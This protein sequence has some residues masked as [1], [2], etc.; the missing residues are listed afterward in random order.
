M[1]YAT[2][3]TLNKV[4]WKIE[5][6]YRHIK[7]AHGNQLL[8]FYQKNGKHTEEKQSRTIWRKDKTWRFDQKGYWYYIYAN[9]KGKYV[10]YYWH[11]VDDRKNEEGYVHMGQRATFTVSQKFK[12][13]TGKTFL[14]AF[15]YSDKEL[16]ACTPRPLYY[17][18]ELL[19][20]KN[21][22]Y[23]NKVD[24]SSCFPSALKGLLPSFRTDY[25]KTIEGVAEP[26]AE[27]PFAFYVKSG[28]MAQKG[29]FDTRTWGD[30]PLGNCL[31]YNADGKPHY[32][33]VRPSE[34]KTILCKASEYGFD[35][36][37]D[38]F[39]ELRNEDPVAKDIMNSFIGFLHPKTD[40]PTYRL[41]HVAAVALAR[42]NQK[43]LDLCDKIGAPYILQVVVDGIIYT[44][45]LEFGLHEKKIG[46]PFQEISMHSFRMRATN[47]YAFA[48]P[49]TNKVVSLEKPY[50]CHAGLDENIDKTVY[51]EDIEEWSQSEE[52]K[53]K[54]REAYRRFKELVP[55]EEQDEI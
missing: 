21:I 5:A 27:Y 46:E 45:K 25:V 1:D 15:G 36:E 13:R 8:D 33:K 41:F 19:K 17:I 3:R 24:I 40:R 35:E 39:Y 16:R 42:A 30:H 51:L 31:F 32:K 37:M 50:V 20:H 34:E 43:M 49:N 10:V 2:K 28:H 54:Q 26:T 53:S 48:D 55:K 22:K 47:I 18:N 11:S 44:G 38:F 23:A 9:E 29:V 52:M 6:E 12:E 7:I 14:G 4:F